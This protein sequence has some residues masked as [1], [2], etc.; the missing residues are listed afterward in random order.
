M[1]SQTTLL[2]IL[3]QGSALAQTGAG[4]SI[5]L[6]SRR[7]A[8]AITRFRSHPLPP[9]TRLSGRLPKLVS[10]TLRLFFLGTSDPAADYL[11]V[12]EKI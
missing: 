9:F 7:V 5:G 4:L 2:Q 12:S 8:E 3:P 10:Q 6:S 11:F 1:S